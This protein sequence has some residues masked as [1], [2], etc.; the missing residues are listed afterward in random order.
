MYIPSVT[1][2]HPIACHSWILLQHAAALQLLNEICHLLRVPSRIQVVI[3]L[4]DDSITLFILIV[5]DSQEISDLLPLLDF[6]CRETGDVQRPP[7]LGFVGF[8][9]FF[10]GL[11]MSGLGRER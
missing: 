10:K 8:N 4:T 3:R 5:Q 6:S 11:G 9:D 1:D 2:S 7:C